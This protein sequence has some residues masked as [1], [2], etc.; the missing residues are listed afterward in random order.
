MPRWLRK[1]VFN[2]AARV[3]TKPRGNYNRIL[4]TDLETLRLTIRKGDVVLVDGDQRVSEVI[5]YLTQSSWSHV[6][7]YVGDELL[8]RF[9]TRREELVRLHGQD[10]Q[11]LIIEALNEGVVASP[12]AKYAGFN[13]RVC[14]PHGLQRD[15]LQRILNEVLAQLGSSYDLKN[16][17]DLAR[18]FF[19][20]SLIPRRFRQRA[21][22]RS[23]RGGGAAG[24]SAPA[25]A[26]RCRPFRAA[27]AR[28]HRSRGA[29]GRARPA[30]GRLAPR[31]SLRDRR[32]PASDARRASARRRTRGRRPRAGRARR[33]LPRD[34]ASRDSTERRRHGSIVGAG[35]APRSRRRRRAP[36]RRRGGALLPGPRPLS[37]VGS[38]RGAARRGGPR[39]GDGARLATPRAAD[40]R[41]RTLPREATR[42]LLAR[43]ARVR[44]ARR[45]RRGGTGAE[46]R[47]GMAPGDGRLRVDG[48]PRR[49][50]RGPRRR[51]RRGDQRGLARPRAL[52]EPRH[53]VHGLRDAR[54]A[55]RPPLARATAAAP[56]DA[57][58]VLRRGGR[59]ADQ[60][61]ARRPARLRTRR[62]RGARIPAA[63][64]VARGRPRAGPRPVRRGC[65]VRGAAAPP[66]RPPP[67][68]RPPPDERPPSRGGEPARG[69]DLVLRALAPRPPPPVDAARAGGARTCRARPPAP[70][71]G[72]V[73]GVRPA[74]PDPRPREARHLRAA[75]AAAARA[76]RRPRA[77]GGRRATRRVRHPSA[78]GGGLA[79]RRPARRRRGDGDGG[80]PGV[81]RGRARTHSARHRRTRLGARARPRAGRRAPVR[82]AARAPRRGA[83]APSDLHPLLGAR[84]DRAAQRRGDRAARRRDAAR[85]GDRLREPGA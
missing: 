62:P 64:D 23:L 28:A 10:A 59:H 15:D 60:G 4:P 18:Y 52:R 65:C 66:A 25:A 20:V 47:S 35:A 61:A 38:G 29:A 67:A 78:R 37:A 44:R 45:R 13:T 34:R 46:R 72:R 54:R 81:P 31:A 7:L 69:A 79:R 42:P 14:R 56:A 83:D 68:P 39:D 82:G 77:R 1:K 48:P 73:G 8:R 63:P 50:G 55:R 26:W 22:R 5:K 3:L 41:A 36:R 32:A 9:P 84:G 16:L 30:P 24:R 75:G 43:L 57:R 33:G 6:A 21:R 80:R 17:L 70:R 85:A 2:V 27:R 49:P 71:A 76:D 51:A 58:A 11:H 12:L 40:A 74:P 19:A 53:D